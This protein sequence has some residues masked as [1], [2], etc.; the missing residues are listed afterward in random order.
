MSSR[1]KG[2]GGDPESRQDLVCLR[3]KVRRGDLEFGSFLILSPGCSLGGQ[4]GMA[5]R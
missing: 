1:G 2:E 4:A 3:V 5:G